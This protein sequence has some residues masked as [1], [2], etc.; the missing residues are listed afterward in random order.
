MPIV[1]KIPAPGQSSARAK[2]VILTLALVQ[3]FNALV[4]SVDIR[5][6][7]FIFLTSNR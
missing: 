2:Q 6:P 5:V 7:H 4:K 3:Q 1:H